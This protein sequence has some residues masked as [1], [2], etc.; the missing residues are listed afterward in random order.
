MTA[1]P[2]DV[3]LT[4]DRGNSTLDCRVHAAG[5]ARRER[6][7]PADASAFAAFLGDLHID[8]AAGCSVVARGLDLARTELHR[9]GVRLRVAGAELICPLSIGYDDPRELGHDRWVAAVGARQVFGDAL[10]VDCGT[11]VTFG[12]VFRDGR[13]QPGPIGAGLTTTAHALGG[14]APALPAFDGQVA[15]SWPPRGTLDAIRAGVGGQFAVAVEATVARLLDSVRRE[16]DEA[17]QPTLVV[18]GG[19]ANGFLAFASLDWRT[20]PELVHEGLRHLDRAC[21]SSC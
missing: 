12:C 20:A 2:V 18:T 13:Y 9:R 21:A 17:W 10:I 1:D 6:L 16:R 11:A 4:I 19:D 14:R 3:V 7:D 5:L 8:R 15:R